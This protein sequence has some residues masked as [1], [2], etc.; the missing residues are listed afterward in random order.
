[1]HL[2]ADVRAPDPVGPPPQRVERGAVVFR[3]PGADV[4][5]ARWSSAGGT[6]DLESDGNG[7]SA[8]SKIP[9]EYAMVRP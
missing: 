7:A 3:Q 5:P 4:I 9:S 6:I 2:V 8:R 1:V